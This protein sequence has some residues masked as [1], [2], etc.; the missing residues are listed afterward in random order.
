MADIIITSSPSTSLQSSP[1]LESVDDLPTSTT[2]NRPP[3]HKSAY[4]SVS[5]NKPRQSTP[6]RN[7]QQTFT[8]FSASP[9]PLANE[10]YLAL[11]TEMRQAFV[12]PFTVETF[13]KDFLPVRDTPSPLTSPGF[14]DV[15][16]ATSEKQMYG[17][18][19]RP[20]ITLVFFSVSYKKYTGQRREL[21]LHPV[22]RLRHV[23]HPI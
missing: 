3:D 7:T 2:P 12:G 23:Q 21:A 1:V 17:S 9:P 11:D 20:F 10:L 22:H 6:V 13:F 16:R 5:T 15:A 8:D 19:V 18:F 14:T 4:L